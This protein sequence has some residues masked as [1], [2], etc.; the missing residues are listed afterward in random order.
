MRDLG[1]ER[2]WND[3]K[4]KELDRKSK[5][6]NRNWEEAD[7]GLENGKVKMENGPRSGDE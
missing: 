1:D 7:G 5:H 4:M 3:I 6:E 2:V